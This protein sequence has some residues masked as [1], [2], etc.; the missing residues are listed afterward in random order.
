MSAE[1]SRNFFAERDFMPLNK[2]D[3]A[4][5]GVM[6][7]YNPWNPSKLQY[8]F[9][10]ILVWVHRFLSKNLLFFK[11][12]WSDWCVFC[13]FPRKCSQSPFCFV[14]YQEIATNTYVACIS[15]NLPHIFLFPKAV[16][17]PP[18]ICLSDRRFK[19]FRLKLHHIQFLIPSFLTRELRACARASYRYDV[20]NGIRSLARS[21]DWSIPVN[22][23]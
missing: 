10:F 23:F 21:L 12:F 9:Y 2:Q 7:Y 14:N 20:G 18:W 19:K 15:L 11:Y 1:L 8:N 13:G 16:L 4:D 22:F 3:D 6:F 5:T 17:A